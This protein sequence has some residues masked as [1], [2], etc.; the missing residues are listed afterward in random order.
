MKISNT[1]SKVI[2]NY[3]IEMFA[4]LTPHVC[5]NEAQMSLKNV[6]CEI[7]RLF[8]EKDLCAYSSN[9][10]NLVLL[11]DHSFNLFNL[12]L[13]MYVFLLPHLR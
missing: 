13:I 3:C 9:S 11:S 5:Y 12:C 10:V 2:A 6:L 4:V 8:A 7:C 1:R